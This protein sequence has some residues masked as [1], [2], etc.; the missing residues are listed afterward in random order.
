MTAVIAGWRWAMLDAAAPNL[1]QTAV[2]VS[3]AFV[4]FVIGLG[5]FRSS[6]PRF[7]DTI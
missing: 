6:E 4:L 5:V 2:G 7:A 3:V 1:G